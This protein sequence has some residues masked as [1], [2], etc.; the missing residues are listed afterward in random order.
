MEFLTVGRW[1]NKVGR[2]SGW[3]RGQVTR[4]CVDLAD[5]PGILLSSLNGIDRDFQRLFKAFSPDVGSG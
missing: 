1:L 4:T 5:G 3:T 2:T